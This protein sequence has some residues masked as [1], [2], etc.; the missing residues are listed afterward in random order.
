VARYPIPH[1]QLDQLPDPHFTPSLT[2]ASFVAARQALTR[3]HSY[4][5]KHNDAAFVAVGSPIDADGE[6]S[7]GEIGHI[8]ADGSL[9]VILSLADAS[10]AVGNQWGELHPPAGRA[11][12]LP[13]TYVLLYAP[14][15]SREEAVSERLLD[16]AAAHMI[17]NQTR[18]SI[19]AMLDSTS[20]V[21]TRHTPPAPIG[22]STD[23]SP[24]TV[25][26]NDPFRPLPAF[27]PPGAAH[28]VH[29]WIAPSRWLLRRTVLATLDVATRA[30]LL[31]RAARALA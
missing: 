7:G 9:H 4:Y 27:A 29:L 12:G 20:K 17:T 23:D 24:Y 26:R 28:R 1:G 18:R 14:R 30:R 10:Q 31:R 21:P 19:S 25:V 22:P 2:I 16:A 13:R 11:A 6:V 3:R 15:D 5:E 8:H